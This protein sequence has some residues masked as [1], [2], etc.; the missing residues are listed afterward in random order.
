MDVINLYKNGFLLI[1]KIYFH[2]ILSTTSHLLWHQCAAVHRLRITGVEP[3]GGVSVD[4]SDP[5]LLGKGVVPISEVEVP[6]RWIF[7]YPVTR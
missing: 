4:L 3:L 7:L 1:F 2:N 6:L 5:C